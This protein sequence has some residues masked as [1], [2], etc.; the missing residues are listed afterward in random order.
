[1]FTGRALVPALDGRRVWITPC[2]LSLHPRDECSALASIRHGGVREL[3]ALPV[4]GGDPVGLVPVS[5]ARARGA[6]AR[7]TRIRC[8]R[9]RIG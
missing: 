9:R 5:G 4:G 7:P 2:T 6:R 1:M 3:V 8:H